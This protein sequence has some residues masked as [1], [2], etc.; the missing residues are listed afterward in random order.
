MGV[1]TDA[2]ILAGMRTPERGD[3]TAFESL[4]Q[5][6]DAF[7]GVG[8]VAVFVEAADCVFAETAREER[9]K[10]HRGLTCWQGVAAEMLRT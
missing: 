6:I 7:G 3:A 9:Q 1:N 4:A 10:C 8:A 2:S 5:S